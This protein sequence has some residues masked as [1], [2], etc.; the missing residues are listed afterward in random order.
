M[1]PK[2]L[3]IIS[4]VYVPDPASVG[5]HLADSA[6]EMVSRGWRVVVITS[7]RGYDDPSVRYAPRD[8]INGVEIVRLPL[9]SFGKKS[10]P[11][12]LIGGVMFLLQA[13]LRGLFTPGLSEIFVSTSPPMCPPVAVLIGKLR[14][15]PV[16]YWAMD[17]NPDQMIMLG[18]I[19]KDSLPAR[20]FNLFNRIILR[21]A[22]AVITL[23]RFMAQ[24]LNDKVPVGNRMAVFPPWA[25]EDHLAVVRHADNPFRKA[26]KLEDKFVFMYSGNM[27]IASPLTTVLAAAEKLRD[28]PRI[29]F[30]FIG[31]GLGKKVVEAAIRDK[32]LTNARLLP[33]QPIDQLKNSLSAADVHLVALGDAM[34]GVIHPCKIY[35]AMAV[36]R[37]VLMFGPAPSHLSELIDSGRIG[38]RVSHGDTETA[39]RVIREIA[40]LPA[41][42]LETMG[43][44][45]KAMLTERYSRSKLLGQLG[46]ALEGAAG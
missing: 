35:G 33:Y 22:K 24:R 4:Q 9:S 27:S 18:A 5:Q 43:G 20:V 32:G 28:D 15:V 3:L 14:R 1:K 30:M 31:G 41:A 36:A 39:T 37:P 44:R 26:H 6:A 10:I 42:E 25:H 23:D 45:A 8:V 2:T 12:R 21:N 13:F 17:L 46:D 11:V 19:T 16:V 38:W 7:R 34:V 29:V 40:T